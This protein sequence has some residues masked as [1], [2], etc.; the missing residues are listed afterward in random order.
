ML[1]TSISDRN[2]FKG[3]TLRITNCNISTFD[4][5]DGY[6]NSIRKRRTVI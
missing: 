5:N 3:K 4:I 6:T 2:I 1:N